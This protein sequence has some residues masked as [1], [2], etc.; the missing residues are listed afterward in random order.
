MQRPLVLAAIAAA[1][2]SACGSSPSVSTQAPPPPARGQ[3]VDQ[4]PLQADVVAGRFIRSA[5]LDDGALR[6]SPASAH[7]EPKITQQQARVLFGSDESIRGSSAGH[8]LGYGIISVQPS[9]GAPAN[10]TAAWVGFVWGGATSCPA[11]TAPTGPTT[12]TVPPPTPGYRAVIIV[13]PREVYDYQ[14]RGSSC[15]G[16]ATGPDANAASEVIS[17]PWQLVSLQ[18]SSVT[19]RY[20]VPACLVGVQPEPSLGG[21]TNT[22][23]GTLTIELTLPFNRQSCADVW[24]QTDIPFGP[25][26]GPGA[27]PFPHLKNVSHGP[28]GPLGSLQPLP[29]RQKSGEVRPSPVGRSVN[30]DRRP[31]GAGHENGATTATEAILRSTR[32]PSVGTASLGCRNAGHRRVRCRRHRWRFAGRRCGRFVE[33]GR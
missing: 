21:N 6:V 8:L 19:V 4:P 16:P 9:L 29:D 2:L 32:S 24:R 20:Q 31:S 25:P 30:R 7:A 28:T 23:E 3:A 18:M 12:T 1:A 5:E 14:S 15:G 33:C 27:P 17:V 26:P 10:D 11:M 22:G 13:D